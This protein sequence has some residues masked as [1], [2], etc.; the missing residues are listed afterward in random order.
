MARRGSGKRVFNRFC[1]AEYSVAGLE[2]RSIANIYQTFEPYQFQ[3]AAAHAHTEAVWYWPEGR[4]QMKAMRKKGGVLVAAVGAI[5][6]SG[7]LPP[8]LQAVVAAAV[9]GVAL[10]ILSRRRPQ[11]LPVPVRDR[12][13]GRF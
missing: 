3:L 1:G 4:K 7:S 13:T 10:A 2:A 12:R 6:L 11:L 9:A 5:V 8:A